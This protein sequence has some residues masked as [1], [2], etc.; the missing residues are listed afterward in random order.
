MI[1]DKK[2]NLKKVIKSIDLF[3]KKMYTIREVGKRT[4]K[5]FKEKESDINDKK[6]YK[7]RNV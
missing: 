2:I 1:F 5:K 7:K 6:N 3:L 4:S